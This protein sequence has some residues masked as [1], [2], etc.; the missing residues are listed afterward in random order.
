[1][2]RAASCRSVLVA[3]AC[4]AMGACG[5]AAPAATSRSTIVVTTSILGD[6]VGG[7]VGDDAEVVVL[8]PPGADP[9]DFAP[10]ARQA[11]TLRGADLVVANGLGLEEGLVDAL[12]ATER[13][14]VPVVEVAPLIDP[15]S[16]SGEEDR[17]EEEAE[18]DDG[19]DHGPL[20][21]HVWQDPVRMADAAEHLAGA[22]AEVD[23]ALPDETW[24]ERGAAYAARLGEVHDEIV[25]LLA[26]VPAD[27]RRVVTTHDAFGYLAARYDLEVVGVIVPG[28]STLAQP[29]AAHLAELADL[30]ER[31]AIPAILAEVGVAA[32]LAAT[33]AAEV[34]GDVEVVTLHGDA[35]GPPGSGAET[36]LGLLRTN[37]RAIAAALG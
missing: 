2:V 17:H 32:D 13:D 28:G 15:L 27:R 25:A 4:L 36:Y 6:V 3:A 35:L 11:A 24:D 7:I 33:L 14:G 29:S 1:M 23:E 21:P 20:D 31:E 10:S 12:A 16:S 22:I 19:H 30:I 18:G 8:M 5:T 34:G 26:A 9:H 37:A